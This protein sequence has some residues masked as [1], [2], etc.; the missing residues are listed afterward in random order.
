MLTIRALHEGR[1]LEVWSLAEV[2]R[3]IEKHAGPV[4]ADPRRARRW[5]GSEAPTGVQ[6]GEGAAADMAR[7]GWPLD[8]ALADLGLNPSSDGLP[9]EPVDPVA[10]QIADLGF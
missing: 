4:D 2:A 1:R 8:A 6:A 7:S 10:K 3:L 9:A 5:E